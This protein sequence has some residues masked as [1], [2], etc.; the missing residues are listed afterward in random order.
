MTDEQRA[1]VDFVELD[2]IE[3]LRGMLKNCVSMPDENLRQLKHSLL[4]IARRY[5]AEHPADDDE[6]VTEE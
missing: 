4:T 2:E 6:L 3:S 1:A 5:Y